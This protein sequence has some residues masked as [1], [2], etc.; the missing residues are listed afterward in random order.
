MNETKIIPAPPITNDLITKNNGQIPISQDLEFKLNP[1]S[2]KIS[3]S[4]YAIRT[5]KED[6]LLFFNDVSLNKALST[7]NVKLT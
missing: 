5:F 6:V 3:I 1:S 4:V 7:E 2:N